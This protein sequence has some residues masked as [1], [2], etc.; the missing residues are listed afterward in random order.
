MDI[1]NKPLTAARVR[2]VTTLGK[3][4]DGNGLYLRVTYTGTKR[5]VLRITIDGK[6][7]HTG[8]GGYPGLPLA[9]ARQAA[10]ARQNLIRDGRDPISEKREVAEE[11][12]KPAM[13]T[14]AYAAQ[15]VIASRQPT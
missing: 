8:L 13:P 3:Y 15:T 9:E 6:R 12:R 4:A 7:H 5:W 14:F 10:W 1:A 11:Q 2:T